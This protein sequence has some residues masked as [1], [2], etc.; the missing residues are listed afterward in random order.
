VY[1]LSAFD[2][3][4]GTA[5]MTFNREAITNMTVAVNFMMFVYGLA[6]VEAWGSVCR[7]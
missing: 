3:P 4:V 5:A 2:S 1:Q 7:G 6:V